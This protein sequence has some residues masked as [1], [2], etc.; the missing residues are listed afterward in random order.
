MAT[1]TTSRPFVH[2]FCLLCNYRFMK[3]HTDHLIGR[4]SLSQHFEQG[5]L[6]RQNC[7]RSTHGLHPSGGRIALTL[8]A[9][10]NESRIAKLPPTRFGRMLASSFAFYRAALQHCWQLTGTP[11]A[12]AIQAS[13]RLGPDGAAGPEGTRPQQPAH[14]GVCGGYVCEQLTIHY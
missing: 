8:L 13:Q 3:R 12:F 1:I 2:I 6:A 7:P 5:R 10:S 11:L 14:C 4:G 9:V